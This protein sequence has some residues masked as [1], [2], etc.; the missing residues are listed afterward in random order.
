MK[1]PAKK[2]AGT[3]RVP[4]PQRAIPS[5]MRELPPEQVAEV[6][7]FVDFLR[8]GQ[9]DRRSTHAA[10]KMSEEVLAKVWSNSAD[11]S[12]DRL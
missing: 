8:Q 11:A 5:K 10:S 1:G 7:A 3:S 12:Y 4:A 6:E 9:E 2:S